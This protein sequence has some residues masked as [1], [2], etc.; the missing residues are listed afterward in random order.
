ME[1]R[2]CECGTEVEYDGYNSIE[3]EEGFF[4]ITGDAKC[5]NCGKEYK[6]QEWHRC[7]FEKPF[8]VELD[9]AE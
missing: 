3:I 9:E 4:I 5:I 7:N 8:D 1:T 2:K 6:Y